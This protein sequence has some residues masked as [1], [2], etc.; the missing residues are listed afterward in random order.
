VSTQNLAGVYAAALTPLKGDF[1]PDLEAIPPLLAFY[2]RRGCHGALLLGTTGEGPSFAPEEKIGIFRA[3]SRVREEY[4]DFRL[5]AGTGTPSLEE[6]SALSRAAFD[7]GFDAVV[8]LPPYF[9]RKTTDEGLLTWFDEVIGNS[10]PSGGA[11]LG[12]H[13]PGLSGVPLSLDLLSRLKDS[14]PRCFAGIK[15]SSGDPGHAVD[16][17]KRFGA[18]L[19]VLTG[20]DNLLSLAIENEASGC[21]TAPANLLSPC[22]RRV[23]EAHQRGES[24]SETQAQLTAWRLTLERYRPYAASL[25]ALMHIRHG[26]PLWPVCPPLLP[27]PEGIAEI[28]LSELDSAARGMP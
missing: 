28:I 11:L 23:W 18:E 4:P 25:K 17:G 8:V 14:H 6:T 9:F 26:F 19:T 5:M 16:L 3:A 27:L 10:V 21:I 15:D 12:Y 1:K 2:A 13:F 7:L 22:L 20:A 24:D